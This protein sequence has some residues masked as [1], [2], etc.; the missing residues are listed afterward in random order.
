VENAA[1][2]RPPSVD[3]LQ[4]ILT[5]MADTAFIVDESGSVLYASPDVEKVF[6]KLDE[7]LL[8]FLDISMIAGGGG[9][10]REVEEPSTAPA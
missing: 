10:T 6:D 5:A 1:G 4:T 2:F 3:L 9:G 7:R 8:I